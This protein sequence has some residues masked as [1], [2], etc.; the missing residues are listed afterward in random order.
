[1]CLCL[2]WNKYASKI[3]SKISEVWPGMSVSDLQDK[4][5]TL[6]QDTTGPKWSRTC[7]LLQSLFLWLIHLAGS[8]HF[9]HSHC[10]SIP[11]RFQCH[12]SHLSPFFTTPSAYNTLPLLLKIFSLWSFSVPQPTGLSLSLCSTQLC[13]F[14]NIFFH[15][16]LFLREYKQGRGREKEARGS[17]AGSVPIAASPMWGSNSW[18]Q[19]SWPEPKSD[20]QPTEPPRCPILNFV[21]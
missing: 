4:A 17:K 2:A 7:L 6:Q 18:T 20:A 13:S 9:S 19:R 21:L 8:R 16:C 12:S 11:Q 10:L 1:M 5:E 14:K 15:V 3:H